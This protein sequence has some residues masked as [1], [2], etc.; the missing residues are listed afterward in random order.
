[1]KRFFFLLSLLISFSVGQIWADDPAPAGTTLI[2]EDFSSYAKDA[3]PSGSV[4][5]ATGRVV[6]GGGN[7]SYSCTGSGTKIYNENTGGG[8]APEILIAKNG[9]TF[10]I[11][12]I[13]SGGAKAITVS[14]TQN[15]QALSVEPSG[16][17]Y[18]GSISGKP[19]V[20]GTR[21][22]DITVADGAAA[23]FTLVFKGSGSSNVRVDDISVTVKTAGEGAASVCATPTFDPATGETFSDNIDVEIACETEGA[24]IYYTTDGSDPTTSSNTYSTALNFTET[25][26]LKAMAVKA[27]YNN[28]AIATATYTKITPVLGY[29]IDFESD[30]IVYVNWN[31]SNLTKDNAIT[32]HG[33]SYYAKTNGTNT[34]SIT[35]KE[36]VA[37][38]G[39]LTYY[40]SKIGTNTN[41]NSKW[42]ARVSEDGTNWTIVGTEYGAGAG[43]TEGTWNECTADLTSYSNVYVQVYYDGTSAVRT[44]DDISLTTVTPGTVATPTISGATPFST[45]TTVT[46]DCTTDDASIYYTTDGTDPTSSSAL[47]ENPFELSASATV[48][49]IAIKG[50]SS[51]SIASKEFTKVTSYTTLADIFTKATEV[52]ST[53]TDIYVTFDSWK[54]SAKNSNNAFLT[55]GT[56]GAVIYGSGHG[57]NAGDVLTGTAACKVQ[58]YKGFAELTTLTSSTTGLTVTSGSVGDPVVKTWNQLS[59]VNTGVLVK[60]EN[61]TYDGSNLS[62]GVN[63]IPTY[64]T[65]YTASFENG[66]SYNLTGVY[67]YY[68]TNGQILPRS[69][70]DIEEIVDSDSS[71]ATFNYTD[72]KDEGTTSTGSE[73]TM[74][75]TDVSIGS[76][77]FFG[78]N[79]QAH[80]YANGEITVTPATGVTIKEIVINTTS[81]SYNGY[82]SS[83]TITASTGSIAADSED[84]KIVRWT[85]SADV[86]FTLSNNK[87]I[88]WTTIVVTYEKADPSAPSLAVNPNVIDFGDV[89]QGESVSAKTVAVNFANLTGTVTYS[90]LSSP[91]SA[92]GSIS[93]TGDEITISADATVAIGE[94]EQTLTVTSAADSKS[95]TVTVTMNVVAA[96]TGEK[97]VKV[98]SNAGIVEGTYLI[99]YEEGSLAFN[100]GLETL[101]AAN[102]TIE[103]VITNDNKIGVTE[104]T[105][106]ATFYIDP[107][108]GTIKAASG[109]YIGVTSNSNGLKQSDNADAYQNAFAIDGDGN[110]VISA[111]FES[112]NMTMRYNKGSG[113]ER[114]RY[115]G[116]GQQPIALYKLANEVIKSDPELAWSGD[117]EITVGGE[118]TSPTLSH[119]DGITG[120]ITYSSDKETVATVDEYGVISLVADATGTAHITA[121]Y[122]GDANFKDGSAVCTIK[123]NPAHSI[124]VSP[125]LTV[126]FG[127][128]VKDAEVAD[129]VI[130]ITLTGV[131]AATATIGGTNPE[132]F[133]FTPAALTESGD[134]TISASSTAIGEFEAKLT[135]SDDAGLA[136]SKVVT[137]KL[138]VNDPASVETPV[139]TSSKWVAA[140][141]IT[142]GM[143]VLI[144]GVKDEVVYAMGEQKS[145]NRAAYAAEVDGEGV[146]T[147]GEG[148]MAFTLVAQGDGTYAIRT[149]DGKYLYAGKN[150]ANH[151]K[152]QAEVDVNAKWTLSVTSAVATG[153][154]NRNVMQFN[155]SGDNKLFSCYASANQSAIQLYKKDAQPEPEPEP[156]E[157]RPGLE[158]GRLYSACMT[159]NIIGVQGGILWDISHYE[160]TKVYF[161]EI[162][163]SPSA[164]LTAG[165]PFIFT[166]TGD[167]KVAYSGDEISVLPAPSGN[168]ALRGTFDDMDQAAFNTVSWENSNSPIYMLVNNQLRQVADYTHTD[169]CTG[170][171]LAANRAYLL[172][173]AL[174]EGQPNLAPGRRVMTMSVEENVATDINFSNGETINASKIIRN[175]QILILRDGKTFDV[176]GRELR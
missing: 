148:T 97:F 73:Y 116:N 132:V 81:T 91:F 43:V 18:T 11:A 68:D 100:G 40:I 90:G 168:S 161:E 8:T 6:Y 9:G 45:A 49:A 160:G 99:V 144:T 111:V 115:Y 173:S 1:M 171:S 31:F 128:V 30:L 87:Q 32:A 83:G 114:F 141:E 170:N 150:D 62:D 107:S 44:I 108:A 153:S 52:G 169:L 13:P 79:N 112:A 157:L 38:P 176:T 159:Q 106:A 121:S 101:D 145:T 5:T 158:Q 4:T 61:L 156:E 122:A 25:T 72:Y 174:T 130:T 139:S 35:T 113:Q 29:E 119:A 23:T 77:T 95:A 46:L 163:V 134:I 51:S 3:V 162:V 69:A 104:Q 167:F 14:F 71:P 19:S 127:S 110:A 66:K 118:F 78:N 138:T 129:K 93:T 109:K 152:T 24:T 7:V 39:T 117:V 48:K 136:D 34:A 166:V 137:L 10:V 64:T 53:A 12:G 20:V 80:F 70:A 58:L 15:K 63:T 57:F 84:A 103:V 92:S 16:T 28:S 147:P 27:N 21:T 76:T 37:N 2:S 36:K 123:V 105:A 165:R 133:S 41:A 143:Q 172:Y 125:S 56:N 98:T 65:F 17:G 88:R 124:Y 120:T 102:N 146:L 47:Y 60:L 67:Q 89:E 126:N 82:Q 96:E 135:I 155:G 151:L 75:K 85:G 164:P 86:A 26:T 131:D 22:F 59:A 175:G 55:D 149:S 74:V 42:K 50:S 140:T 54:I 33:G 154:S 142:D 94:Y